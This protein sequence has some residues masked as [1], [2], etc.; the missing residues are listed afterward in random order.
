MADTLSV[1]DREI[2]HTQMEFADYRAGEVVYFP[3]DPSETVYSVR[4]GK[5]RLTY[6]DESGRRLTFAIVGR[7]QLFGESALAGEESRNWLAEAVEDTTVCIIQRDDL[8][9]FA[10]NNPDLSLR[11]G[12][13]VGDRLSEIE[14]KLE[15]L[16]FKNVHARLS[17]TLLNLSESFGERDGEGIRLQFRVTHQEL[18]NLIGATRETTSLALGDLE[19]DG[20]LEKERGSITLKDPE[21]LRL[22]S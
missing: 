2:L 10:A 3:G 4:E 20:L 15:D 19:R 1:S 11:I 9:D 21:K 8:L 6:L 7:G 16:L 14:N 13:E 5:V 18:A 22:R 12:K 17:T